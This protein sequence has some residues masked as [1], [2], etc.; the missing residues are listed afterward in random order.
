MS[1]LLIS[2]VGALTV[3]LAAAGVSAQDAGSAASMVSNVCSKCH[4]PD[5]VSQSSLFP[6]LAGQQE[7]YLKAQLTQFRKRERG[8]PHAQAYMW[9]LAGSLSD[10]QI[11][12]LAKY[13]STKPPAK[14]EP[15]SDKAL[16]ARGKELYENGDPSRDIPACQACHG[17]DA[18]GNG[19]VPRLAGQHANYLVSQLV[20]FRGL[21]RDNPIMHQNTLKLEDEQAAALAAYLSSL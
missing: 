18:S 15:G 10:P 16:I 17:E 20:A 8:D 2:A 11:E 19:A 13:F 3:A 1:K 4:G 6:D 5:G 9:G 14:G 12:S 7:E 21:L